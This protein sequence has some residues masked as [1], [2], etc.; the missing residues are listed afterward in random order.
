MVDSMV[1]V[2][3]EVTAAS[4]NVKGKTN[5]MWAVGEADG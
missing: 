3:T 2:G 4:L 5:S 1:P